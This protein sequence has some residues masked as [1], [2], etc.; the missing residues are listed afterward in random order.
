MTRLDDPAWRR[1]LLAWAAVVLAACTPL[2]SPYDHAAYQNA[3]AAKAEVLALVDK[4]T[5][6]YSDHARQVEDMLLAVN[7]AYEYARGLPQN[8]ITARQWEILKDPN[9]NLIGGFVSTWKKQG[10]T[11]RAYAEEKREQLAEAFD[12]LIC[13]EANKKE[14]A[15][16]TKAEGK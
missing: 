4:A 14:A 11:S 9:G 7:K 1:T 10:R 5:E 13:L 2:I 8:R 16:C 12:Y 6:P 15:K 3:T